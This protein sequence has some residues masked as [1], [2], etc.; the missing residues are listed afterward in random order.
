MNRPHTPTPDTMPHGE[1][2]QFSLEEVQRHWETLPVDLRQ[3]LLDCSRTL[4]RIAAWK[5]TRYEALQPQTSE[6]LR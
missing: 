4:V 5:Q 1:Q 2:G 3:I 6:N